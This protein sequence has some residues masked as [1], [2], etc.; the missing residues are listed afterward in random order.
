MLFEAL[1][2]HL[3]DPERQRQLLDIASRLVE[4]AFPPQLVIENTSWCNLSCI[5]CS[6]REMRRP[7]RHLARELWNTIVEE[8]GAEA[9][10]CELWPTFYGEPLLLGDELWNRL[11]HA[12]RAGCRNLVLNSN[13]TALGGKNNIEKVLNSPLRRFILSLDGLTR[14][15]FEL[16]RNGA[17][18]ERVYPLVAELCRKRQ[19]RGQQY[20]IIIAQF[21]VMAENAHEAEAFR[22]YWHGRGAEVKIRPMLEWGAVGRVRSATISHA[23]PFRIACP[24]AN[25][26]MAILED[27]R[28][29]ACAVDYEGAFSVGRAGETSLKALWAALGTRLRTHHRA[30]RWHELPAL[31]QGC[32]DWQTAGARYDPPA[33][34][35]T[36]PFWYRDEAASCLPA[37]SGS[38][39]LPA[40]SGSGYLPA[41]SGSG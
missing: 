6:H 15:T 38:G 33:V 34:A 27:G 23:D 19:E 26:T 37:E 4:H 13:G 32:G 11:D 29:T 18:W 39:Y 16:V 8:V 21:S 28:A 12:A 25:N 30:H 2:P 9:P 31:C 35:G 7:T 17:R 10:E 36:R 20:P 41:G 14:E 40:E 5:H 22:A 24:W 1:T 3:A